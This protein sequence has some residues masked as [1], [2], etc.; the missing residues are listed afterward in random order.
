[1]NLTRLA[2]ERDVLVNFVVAVIVVG[3]IFSY[4]TMGRLEDP[5]FTIK[6]A[7][8]GSPGTPR[9]IMGISAPPVLAL[10]AASGAAIPSMIPV[11]NSSLLLE[12]LFS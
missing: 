7:V 5:D 12:S 8:I 9:V 4:A 6:T 10:L 1:M 2:L 11:P 3:G